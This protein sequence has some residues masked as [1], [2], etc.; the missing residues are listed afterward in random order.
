MITSAGSTP[1]RSACADV[2]SRVA[3]TPGTIRILADGGSTT[4][5]ATVT[6]DDS[7]WPAQLERLLVA[8]HGPGSV[9]VL[10]AGVP[11]Y[12]VVDNFIRLQSE[13]YRLE[14]DIIVLLQGHNDLYYALVGSPP[15][16]PD[17][18]G[19]REPLTP[20]GSWLA[21]HSLLVRQARGSAPVARRSVVD[22]QLR[23][24][25]TRSR[26]GRLR[27][28]G[29]GAARF[30][31]D[32]TSY[33]L[34]AKQAGARVILIEP[35]HGLGSA[36]GAPRLRRARGLG[37]CLR[38]CSRRGGLSGLHGVWE[39]HARGRGGAGC[40]SS[41]RLSDWG[42]DGPSLYD[43]GDPIHLADAGARRFAERLASVLDSGSAP[44]MQLAP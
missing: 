4:F 29:R 19:A 5:D 26:A 9:E 22:R 16:D 27:G 24:S 34:I 15:G 3:K 21:R 36:D 37:E 18:P 33:V 32:L 42:I 10:N 2:R 20:W 38:R 43:A 17:T 7:T 12:A 40:R 23:F 13:L 41:S 11:G 35:V 8:R 31:R 14:P 1:T 39:G 25:R 28:G 44:E 30:H 6:A